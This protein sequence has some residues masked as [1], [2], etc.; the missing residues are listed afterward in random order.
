MFQHLAT[1]G[2]GDWNAQWAFI[3]EKLKAVGYP[4]AD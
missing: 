3:N 1:A 2:S 4:S